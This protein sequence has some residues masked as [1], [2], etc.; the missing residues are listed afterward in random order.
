MFASA[1]SDIILMCES[2]R[3]SLNGPDSLLSTHRTLF[4][5]VTRL[6]GLLRAVVDRCAAANAEETVAGMLGDGP[7][8]TGP[9][10]P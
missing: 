7:S 8:R 6:D 5:A 2:V 4:H 3:L 9:L 1:S 10:W